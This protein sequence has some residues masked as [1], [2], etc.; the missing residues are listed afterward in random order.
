LLVHVTNLCYSSALQEATSRIL[1]RTKDARQLRELES[2]FPG[3][4]QF[5]SWEFTQINN[6]I[7]GLQTINLRTALHDPLCRV[8]I[9][10]PDS[11]GRTPLHW[12]AERGDASAVRELLLAGANA[13]ANDHGKR[14][15]LHRAVLSRNP[16]CLELPLIAG[17]S[18]NSKDSRGDFTLIEVCRR[19]D[20]IAFTRQL[21]LA[22]ASVNSENLR[23]GSPFAKCA[24]YNH[25]NVGKYLLELGAN[26][27]HCDIDGDTPLFEAIINS[28]YEFLEMLLQRGAGYTHLNGAGQNVLH[29]MTIRSDVRT[30]SILSSARL[31]GVDPEAQDLN[32]RSAEEALRDRV[33][34]PDGFREAFQGLLDSVQGANKSLD[35][36]D[37]SDIFVDAFEV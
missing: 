24:I 3:T 21:I 34:I 2:L 22:G 13:N 19:H 33:T 12:A 20:D 37:E 35:A 31:R 15:P 17:A 27:D 26:I 16:R 6:V 28:S 5:E 36:D 10:L 1:S 4:E 18:A 30:A 9:D 23:G 25:V 32:G 7:L 11:V 8:Q 29:I 14:V